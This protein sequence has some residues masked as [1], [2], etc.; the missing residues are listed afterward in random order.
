M[1]CELLGAEEDL[2]KAPAPL[3]RLHKKVNLEDHHANEVS[4]DH[5]RVVPEKRLQFPAH[6]SLY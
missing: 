6:C 2:A 3:E 4:E 5:E 1:H